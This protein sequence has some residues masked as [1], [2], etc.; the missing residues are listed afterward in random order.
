MMAG[1][2]KFVRVVRTVIFIVAAVVAATA[3]AGPVYD[4]LVGYWKFD[5]NYSDSSLMGNGAL[6]VPGSGT[7]AFATGQVGQALS[8]SAAAYAQTVTNLAVSGQMPRTVNV[9]FNPTAAQT[10]AA[11]AAGTG[12]NGRIFDLYLKSSPTEFGGHFYGGNYDTLVGA[13]PT[14]AAGQW[15]MATLVY[16]GD[17]TVDVYRNGELFKSTTL[18]GPLNTALSALYFGGG[19]GYT[20]TRNYAGMIDDVAVWNRVLTAGEIAAVHQATS[21]GTS[22]G[23]T[24][25][26]A[27]QFDMGSNGGAATGAIG[28]AQWLGA[29]T[30]GSWNVVTGHLAGATVNN[31]HGAPLANPVTLQFGSTATG[32]ITDWGGAVAM[33]QGNNTSGPGGVHGT[34]LMTDFVYTTTNREIMGTRIS[35]LPAGTYDVF[36]MPRHGAVTHDYSVAI[37]ANINTLTGN[38]FTN[39]G[40]AASADWV[41][42]TSLQMGNVFRKRVTIS[43]P[44]DNIAVL[45]DNLGGNSTE[46]MGLQIVQVADPTPPKHFRVQFDA[47]RSRGVPYGPVGPGQTI[48]L[49]SG[50]QW[51]ALGGNFTG[52]IVD[53]FGNPLPGQVT[54]QFAAND[55]T[56]PLTSWGTGT[57]SDWSGFASGL[58]GVNTSEMMRDALYIGSGSREVMGIRMGGLPTGLYEVL[59]MPKY[60][61]SISA[62]RVAI[63]ANLEDLSGGFVSPAG[64]FNTW[65]EGTDSQAGN[66]YRDLVV[67]HGTD[68]WITMIFDNLD[69]SSTEF[70][71]FQIAWVGIPEPSSA[72]LLLT[73]VLTL[74]APSNRRRRRA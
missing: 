19:G 14:Y 6:A 22:L 20:G 51:N 21:G 60:S 72:L 17:R 13:N 2:T 32:S 44:T 65:V 1:K 47:G 35:G 73:S 33:G 37:D 66:Y 67:I 49:F 7:V 61:G 56:Q 69:Y 54:V 43:G 9:W 18:P 42:G 45:F 30:G 16:D 15:T 3:T 62:Q 40:G 68:D 52:T 5:G 25:P 46:I 41:V 28:P 38:A 39:P 63:G 74:L 36:A 24:S 26:L 59:M 55:G 31:E 48:G 12:A 34:A 64:A 57:V 53:E 8:V 29:M 23:Q 70:M 71:G 10:Q 50:N 11:L 58:T 27:V 4:G